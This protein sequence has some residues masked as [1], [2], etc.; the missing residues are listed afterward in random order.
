MARLL[1]FLFANY[2]GKSLNNSLV[3]NPFFENV[4]GTF[5]RTLVKT[6]KNI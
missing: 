5:N 2:A 6:K 3:A 4:P 1:R